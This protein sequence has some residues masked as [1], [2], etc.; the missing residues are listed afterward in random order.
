MPFFLSFLNVTSPFN[1][2]SL[3]SLYCVETAVLSFVIFRRFRHSFVALLR[4]YERKIKATDRTKAFNVC[5]IILT[6][7]VLIYPHLTIVLDSNMPTTTLV[8]AYH[9]GAK[10]LLQE[11]SIPETTYLYGERI[12]FKGD[13]IAYDVIS[14]ALYALLGLDDVTYLILM[15]FITMVLTFSFTLAAFTLLLDYP[16]SLGV[17]ALLMFSKLFIYKLS[18]FRTEAFSMCFLFMS[19]WLAIKAIEAKD[20]KLMVLAGFTEAISTTANGA[21]VLVG[22]SFMFAYTLSKTIVEKRGINAIKSFIMINIVAVLVAVSIFILSVQRVPI[23]ESLTKTNVQFETDPTTDFLFSLNPSSGRKEAFFLGYIPDYLDRDLRNSSSMILLGIFLSGL[24]F[25]QHRDLR[26]I[27]LA[28]SLFAVFVFSVGLFFAYYYETYVPARSGFQRVFP[29]VYMSLA[30]VPFVILRSLPKISIKFGSNQIWR[31]HY[32]PVLAVGVISVVLLLNLPFVSD[33]HKS[34]I[35]NEGYLALR[36]ISENTDPDSTILLTNEWTNGGTRGAAN[37]KVLDDGD[38]P[39]LRTGA[40]ERISRL[41][42]DTR[43]FYMNPKDNYSLLKEYNVT[44]VIMS[45]NNCLGG[46]YITPGSEL[47]ESQFLEIGLRKVLDSKNIR[48][49][50]VEW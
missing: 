36:W 1:V 49:Y 42:N 14:S 34:K 7:V 11:G 44:H 40:V 24:V 6:A 2:Y 23:I 9:N 30:F 33:V 35:S 5:L 37:R 45:F 47:S 20:S 21:I 26:K 12:P 28:A 27:L 50:E 43:A 16:Y 46:I 29:Y 13:Y 25:W 10:E 19:L 18:T 3:V 38:A 31:I 17:T 8:W 22:I 48:I 32:R 39:Y 15:T 41:I 4:D